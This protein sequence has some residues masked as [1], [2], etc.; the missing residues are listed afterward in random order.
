MWSAH[1]C[2]RIFTDSQAFGVMWFGIVWC[3][4]H[5]TLHMLSFVVRV[6]SDSVRF[7]MSIRHY[8]RRQLLNRFDSKKRQIWPQ[9]REL[10]VYCDA[11]SNGR[12]WPIYRCC[13]CF[14]FHVVIPTDFYV[15]VCV[16]VCPRGYALIAYSVV[17]CS[18]LMAF[19][20]YCSRLTHFSFIAN[21]HN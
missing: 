13:T 21:F 10:S 11:N 14:F 4:A 7:P 9:I 12:F 20:V 16:C 18:L 15:C 2:G 5:C 3:C 8:F 19:G 17:Q 1:K 6:C